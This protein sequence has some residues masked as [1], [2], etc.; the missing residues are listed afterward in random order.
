MDAFTDFSLVGELVY[1][2]RELCIV[3]CVVYLCVSVLHMERRMYH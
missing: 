1:E 2:V 3:S